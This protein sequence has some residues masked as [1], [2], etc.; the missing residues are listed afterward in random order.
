MIAASNTATETQPAYRILVG[1]AFDWTDEAALY[2]A[3]NL[4]LKSPGSEVHVVHAVPAQANSEHPAGVEPRTLELA[5]ETLRDCIEASWPHIGDIQVVAHVCIGD[6]AK[7]ILSA[8]VDVDADLIVVGSHRRSALQRLMGRSVAEHVLHEAHCPVLIAV[9]KD[10]EDVA[11]HIDPPCDDCLSVR[12][13]SG[14]QRFWCERHDKP[15]LQPHIY[16]PREG[17]R[18]GIADVLSVTATRRTPPFT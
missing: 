2:E 6:T 17:G 5:S 3:M 12:A 18:S 1:V 9:Q 14:N 8:A 7:S 11:P 16:V 4:A 13:E 15:Y 10:Y